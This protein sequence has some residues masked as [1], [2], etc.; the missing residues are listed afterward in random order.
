L[1]LGDSDHGHDHDHDHH[2]H[3]GAHD[4]HV[5]NDVQ[6]WTKCVAYLSAQL[7][8]AKSEFKADYEANTKAYLTV[9]KTL[10]A[11]LKEQFNSIPVAQRV[12][13]TAHDA[14]GYLARAYNLKVESLQGYSTAAEFGIKDI[15]NLA[16]FIQNNQIKSIFLESSVPDKNLEAVITHCKENGHTVSIGGKLYSDALGDK[17]SGADTYSAM[18][19]AN[20]NT[21]VNGLK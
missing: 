21:I 15:T 1:E 13:V 7:I 9:L 8:E 17:A 10:D 11:D 4:P 12:L 20:A 5:W 3:H 18:M 6:T 19:R 14:F 16:N 2:D